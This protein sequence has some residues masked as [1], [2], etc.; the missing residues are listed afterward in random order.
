MEDL[1]DER[2]A[3]ADQLMRLLVNVKADSM[4]LPLVMR[5]QNPWVLLLV[6]EEPRAPPNST[7]E[8][9]TSWKHCYLRTQNCWAVR[10]T[11]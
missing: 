11:H 8:R 2:L 10:R 9:L 4:T 7:M 3:M 1:L 6:L 5:N